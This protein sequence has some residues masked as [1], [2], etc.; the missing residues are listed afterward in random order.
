MLK[1]MRKYATG[2][3]VKAI[4]GLI[5]IVFIF[6]GV[7]SFREGDKAVAR[8]GSHEISVMEYQ[9]EYNR[10]LNTA[11]MLYRDQLDEN[12]LRELKLKEK[13]MDA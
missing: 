10:L 6:W 5:I 8:I 12:L 3:M 2:Y 4:F 11:R 1:F 7:G 13:A 9:E